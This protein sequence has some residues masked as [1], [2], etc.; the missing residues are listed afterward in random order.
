MIRP[1][2]THPFWLI[3]PEHGAPETKRYDSEEAAIAAAEQEALKRLGQR[4]F[5]LRAIKQS[6][7]RRVQTSHLVRAGFGPSGWVKL[8]G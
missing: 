1:E 4:V 8:G 3:W 6:M 5:I 7:G 2:D